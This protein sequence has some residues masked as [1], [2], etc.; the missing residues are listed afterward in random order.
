MS[1]KSLYK[2]K[3][4]IFYGLFTS[5]RD[6]FREFEI[7]PMDI[8]F[9]YAHYDYED[10]SGEAHVIFIQDGKLYEVNGSRSW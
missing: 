10:Y 7:D 1:I 4:Q 6:V 9:I 5:E 8:D 3:A 2:S